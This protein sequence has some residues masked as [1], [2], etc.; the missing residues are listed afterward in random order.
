MVECFDRGPSLSL[1][2]TEEEKFRCIIFRRIVIKHFVSRVI[3]L[4]KVQEIRRLGNWKVE[5]F[6]Y[7]IFS[8][9]IFDSPLST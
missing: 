4:L 6:C 3:E 5:G 9:S 2:L 1:Y 8:I 7:D